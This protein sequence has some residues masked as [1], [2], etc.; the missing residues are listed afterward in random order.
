M[1]PAEMQ[2]SID[3]HAR[4]LRPEEAEALMPSEAERIAIDR[5]INALKKSGLYDVQRDKW[6]IR[7]EL[8]YGGG[9]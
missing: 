1:T 5:A 4:F 7:Q 8:N 6:A 9:L 2:A 3:R